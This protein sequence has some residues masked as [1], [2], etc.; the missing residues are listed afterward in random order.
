MLSKIILSR[1]KNDKSEYISTLEHKWKYSKGSM[2]KSEHYFPTSG[3]WVEINMMDKFKGGKM[4]L[5]GKL[6]IYFY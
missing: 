4:M 3:L 5:S 2:S 6:M 1:L